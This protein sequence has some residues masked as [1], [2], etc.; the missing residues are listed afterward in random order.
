VRNVTA[1]A[2]R[3]AGEMAEISATFREAG[4]PGEF[5]AAAEMIYQRIAGFKDAPETPTLEEVLEKLTQSRESI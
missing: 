3:F 4:L 2:W 5:H 1:K